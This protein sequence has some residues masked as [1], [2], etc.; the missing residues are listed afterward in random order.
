MESQSDVTITISHIEYAVNLER[1][2][3]RLSLDNCDKEM[4]DTV[5]FRMWGYERKC[6]G[7]KSVQ[8]QVETLQKPQD[9][10]ESC[11]DKSDSTS[12]MITNNTLLNHIT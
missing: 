3:R 7:R 4:A 6:S 1:G 10:K 5:L 9:P 8:V 11:S 12:F 2:L